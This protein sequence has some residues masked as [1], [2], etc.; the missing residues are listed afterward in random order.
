MHFYFIIVG[1]A[2]DNKGKVICEL[3]MDTTGMS[4]IMAARMHI[5][6][7]EVNHIIPILAIFTG[8]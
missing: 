1:L 2:D 8:K 6:V 3:L 7:T 4:S 5:R